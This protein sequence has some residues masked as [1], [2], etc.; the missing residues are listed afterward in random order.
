MQLPSDIQARL[1]QLQEAVAAELTSRDEEKALLAEEREKIYQQAVE[2]TQYLHSLQQQKDLADSELVHLRL[3]LARLEAQ[4]DQAAEL[5][6]ALQDEARLTSQLTLEIVDLKLAL[7]KAQKPPAIT[8]PTPVE[9]AEVPPTLPKPDL[10]MLAYE[11]VVTGLP[12]FR[13]GLQYL[14]E[15][16][17]SAAENKTTLAVVVMDVERLRDLN[18]YLGQATANLVL[19]LFPPLV[20]PLLKEADRMFR[21]R[22]DEFWLVLPVPK[23]GPLGMKTASDYASE[24]LKRI[25]AE[26]Q[27]PLE[28]ED[29]RITLG[30]A[31]GIACCQGEEAAEA[32][33]DNALLAVAAAKKI[34]HNRASHYV[35]EMEKQLRAR[36][37]LLPQLRQALN[38]S[39]FELR[40]QPIYEL[41]NRQLR[42]V[43]S[44]L[45][46][47]HPLNG[48]TEP[49]QF[50]EAASE[51]GLMVPI[52]E[53]VIYNVCH[54]SKTY[55]NIQWS[56]NVSAQELM[57]ADFGDRVAKA[58]EA[59]RLSKADTLIVEVR[60]AD[61]VSD[62]DRLLAALKN[63]KRFKVGLAIDD[64]SFDRLSLRRLQTL[65]VS[66]LKLGNPVVQALAEP[67]YRNLVKGAVLAAEAMGVKVI[68]EG[69]ES[70]FQFEQL[71]ELGCHWG[72]GY[73]LAAPVSLDEL[74]DKLK[75]RSK[76]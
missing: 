72:Q 64:Y 42:A 45:R 51:S 26:L 43:E 8:L 54:L 47:E 7:E 39:Q 50:L 67:L 24:L 30:L 46:W 1:E 33:L 41:A 4:P 31:S 23:R 36:L 62:S 32:V 63:L 6:Q 68:A 34:G 69:I 21:G 12:N 65:G 3:K 29:H 49:A 58:I 44:L 76:A 15:Q 13:A 66:Y 5:R 75:V 20:K 71:N 74:E 55:R 53:W 37:A 60:E 9:V 11:D 61:L 17:G 59:A 22:D 38:R 70:Q 56:F 40:F 14:T 2:L 35:L 28:L 25:Y 18:R 19:Q 27:T 57:Q 10:Q 48:L 16:L 52:G 73:Y